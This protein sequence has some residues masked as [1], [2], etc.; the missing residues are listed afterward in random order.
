MKREKK[1]PIFV[2]M[3]DPKGDKHITALRLVGS[4]Y[5]RDGGDW[6]VGYKYID[7]K[8]LS[9]HWGY[10]MP[11]LHRA[12]LIEITEAEWRKDNG[13]YAPPDPYGNETVDVGEDLLPF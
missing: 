7:R 5:Y 10:G 1:A 12:K 3:T 4:E 9:W 8:L 13:P 11:W 2:M 6:S